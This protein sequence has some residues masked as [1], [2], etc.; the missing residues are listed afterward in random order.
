MAEVTSAEV[1][2]DNEDGTRG[3]VIDI[4]AVSGLGESAPTSVYRERDLD[5]GKAK[6]KAA[7]KAKIKEAKARRKAARAA[8]EATLAAGVSA[9][10]V[11]DE[12]VSPTHPNA[13]LPE[14]RHG[15]SMIP[16]DNVQDRDEAG[17]RVRA[18]TTGTTMTRETSMMS[19][20]PDVDAANALN[21]SESEEEEY[22]EDMEGDFVF[23]PGLDN[24]EDK[25]FTFQFP[26]S[27]PKF[28]SRAPVEVDG[29][30]AEAAGAGEK[31]DE[32]KDEDKDVKP[33]PAQLR[34]K[35]AA[36]PPPEGR[37]GTLCV[38]KSGKVKLVLGEGESGIVMNV[39]FVVVPQFPFVLLRSLLI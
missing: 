26:T 7:D 9:P 35:R 15:D 33:K 22:E 28:V 1:Y 18:T 17:R 39:G 32:K 36:A 13:I 5:G 31:K 29:D 30:A 3:G 4:E 27:F 37:I 19:E 20:T 21:L 8:R 10:R 11:K 34:R 16:A 6:A 14:V 24:P 25:L 12:P 38:M 23:V 2:S